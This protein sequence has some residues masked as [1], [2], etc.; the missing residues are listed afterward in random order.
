MKSITVLILLCLF[1]FNLAAQSPQAFSY[2]AIA[3][4]KTGIALSEKPIIVKISLLDGSATGVLQ[5]QESHTA[6]TSI[7][8][9]FN[10]S[11]GQG[12]IGSGNF[13]TVN[14]KGGKVFLKSEY[15]FGDGK[16][17]S[18]AGVTQLLS[19][20]YSLYAQNAAK[21]LNDK[22]TL[23]TN[24]IQSLSRSGKALSISKGNTILL[25]DSTQW[26]TA[27]N[28]IFYNNGKV[29]IGTSTPRSF[30]DVVST[31]GNSQ[32]TLNLSSTNAKGQAGVTSWNDNGGWLK[33]TL[34][35]S[36]VSDGAAFGNN[37]EGTVQFLSNFGAKNM[38]MGTLNSQDLILG[39]NNKDR[40]HIVSGGNVG[41]GTKSPLNKL[42]VRGSN[43]DESAL[44]TLGNSDYSHA[45]YLFGGRQNDPN[46]FL[47]WNA[48]DPLRFATISGDNNWASF[49]ER[50][51]IS[52]TGDVGIGTTSPT[53]RLDIRSDT[54]DDVKLFR[55]GNSDNTHFLQLF[56]GRQSNSYPNIA[57]NIGDNLQF[58]NL[59]LTV[60]PVNFIPRMTITSTGNVGIA[61]INPKSR[62]Q[63]SGGD[64]YI[65]NI[66]SGVILKSPN[67]QCW[68]VTIDNAGNI[69]R[70]AIT[71]P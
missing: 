39:T 27:A 66:T 45:L 61:T 12:M 19:V 52:A 13:L 34:L 38:L 24:E 71:C 42:D 22:D 9:I 43:L 20:P 16:G 60:N 11:V 21:S 37:G 54:P 3:L 1:A 36:Q 30:L 31:E 56:G 57:Y 33:A 44:I 68:R 47:T 48:G 26:K 5:Y 14:W 58:G 2:Q 46:P 49:R 41:I 25:P 15:D 64:V 67:G 28:N 63:V 18:L 10:L 29:G 59:D 32:Y 62:V 50:M 69:V 4:S 40:L 51:R 55:I 70:T 23:A 8:G 7:E 65:E 53:A 35:G 6:T 17:F